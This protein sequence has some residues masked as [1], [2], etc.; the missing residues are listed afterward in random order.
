MDVVFEGAI[1]Y[2][3]GI[4]FVEYDAFHENGGDVSI[5][6]HKEL[7]GFEYDLLFEPGVDVMDGENGFFLG[8]K[9]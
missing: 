4:K 5:D 6:C 9:R 8:M 3:K 2:V 1:D 7:H